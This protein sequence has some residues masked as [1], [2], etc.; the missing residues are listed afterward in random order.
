MSS[1]HDNGE[2]PAHR[3]EEV[4]PCV[5]AFIQPDG[6]WWTNNTGFVNGRSGVVANRQLLHRAADPGLPRRHPLGQR[7]RRCGRW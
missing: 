2:L 7:T 3:L 6:S 4:S 1:S 5:F